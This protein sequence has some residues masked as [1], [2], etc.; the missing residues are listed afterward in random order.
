MLK[1]LIVIAFGAAFA[2]VGVVILRL[3][4]RDELVQNICRVGVGWAMLLGGLYMIA[5]GVFGKRK[6]VDKAINDM[7]NGI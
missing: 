5:V 2:P 4:A 6:S 3:P 1:R 7:M